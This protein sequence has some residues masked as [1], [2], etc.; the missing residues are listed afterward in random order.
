MPVLIVLF[1][2]WFQDVFHCQIMDGNIT[3]NLKEQFPYI[4]WFW[5]DFFLTVVFIDVCCCMSLCVFVCF[6]VCECVH[7]CVCVSVCMCVCMRAGVH[8]C[9]CVFLYICM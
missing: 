2:L 6:S 5:W 7:V 8:T 1:V 9:A 4:G 3:Q